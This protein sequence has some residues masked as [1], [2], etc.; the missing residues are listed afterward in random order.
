M[1][2]LGAAPI[3]L[4]Q[5]A[6][7]DG[8]T[9]ISQGN[10]GDGSVLWR[11]YNDGVLI[12]GGGFIEWGNVISPWDEYNADIFKIVF[13]GAIIAGNSLGGLFANL[14]NLTTIENL[15]YFNTAN[16]TDM[17]FMFA[18]AVNLAGLDLSSWDIRYV[19]N[20]SGMLRNTFSLRQIALGEYF[21]FAGDGR[22]VELP[23][24]PSNNEFT[25]FWQNMRTDAVLT[26]SQ[27]METLY[28]VWAWQARSADIC[29]MCDICPE[30]NEYPCECEEETKPQPMPCPECSAYPCECQ[31]EETKPT[32]CEHCDAYPCECEE[33]TEQ[34]RCPECDSYP[35]ECEKYTGGESTEPTPNPPLCAECDE[36]PCVCEYGEKEEKPD[37][38]PV[39]PDGPN[40]PADPTEPNVPVGPA[41]PTAPPPLFV[42]IPP[43]LPDEPSGNIIAPPPTFISI[44]SANDNHE[45]VENQI[46]D[47]DAMAV[48]QLP[49]GV[50]E[51]RLQRR[52]LDLLIA[53][54]T[55]LVI[56]TTAG[57][58]WVEFPVPFIRELRERGTIFNINITPIN[59]N[60]ANTNIFI[61]AAADII[62]TVNG[63][64]LETF[65]NRYTIAADLRGFDF[66]GRNIE[67][68]YRITAVHNARNIGGRFDS[69]TGIFRVR[70]VQTTGEFAIAYMSDLRRI[71]VELE[72]YYVIDL[73]DN[74]PAQT[75]E[76][77]VL[78]IISQ[79]RTLLPVRFMAYMLGAEVTWHYENG[80]IEVTLTLD[81]KVLTFAIGEMAY[82]YG[83]DVPARLVNGRTMVPLRFISEFFG[84]QVEWDDETRSVEIVR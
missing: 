37:P 24:V 14:P 71:H 35:C 23:D 48:I 18:D 83:M 54:D 17:S 64:Q 53:R 21:R 63:R 79:G 59:L 70:S 12:V 25:G 57:I 46:N 52:T 43:Q 19:T 72:S 3:A 31:Q 22:S 45:S 65:N 26:S 15:S 62:F 4:G 7:D 58:I 50:G 5:D 29:D 73:A 80:G 20:I 47:G 2:I 13:S 51:A 11:L 1:L 77:D 60:R 32:V 10:V 8:A 76:M 27:L 55:P 75:I 81:D 84:A 44:P 49:A 30:C 41:T 74:S 16:M 56:A 38:P 34:I 28:G 6:A 78:P 82:G 39:L 61:F 69:A 42:W 66:E 68:I 40:E 9:V 33:E 36:Y 67:N